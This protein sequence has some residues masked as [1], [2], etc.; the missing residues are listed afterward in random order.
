MDAENLDSF[1]VLVNHT[2]KG[3]AIFQFITNIGKLG[4]SNNHYHRYFHMSIISHMQHIAVQCCRIE[5]TKYLQTTTNNTDTTFLRIDQL[6]L[7]H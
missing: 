3:W 6:L 1:C 4:C 5:C 7:Q 2:C